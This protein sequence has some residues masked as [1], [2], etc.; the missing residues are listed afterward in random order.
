MPDNAPLFDEATACRVHPL[1]IGVR[2]EKDFRQFRFRQSG[3]FCYESFKV[4]D[5]CHAKR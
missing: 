2:P 3:S 4:V 5:E 1:L